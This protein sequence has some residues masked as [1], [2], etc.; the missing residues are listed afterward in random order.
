MVVSNRVNLTLDID[1]LVVGLGLWKGVGVWRPSLVH[2]VECFNEISCC[3]IASLTRVRVVSS[4]DQPSFFGEFV[5]R[6]TACGPR[7]HHPRCSDRLHR[8]DGTVQH[9]RS[10]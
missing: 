9:R 2:Y 3:F 8:D 10:V 6:Q 4:T 1:A 7:K 5:K